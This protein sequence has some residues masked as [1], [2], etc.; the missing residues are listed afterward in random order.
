M[1]APRVGSSWKSRIHW[2]GLNKIQVR[3]SGLLGS[4]SSSQAIHKGHTVRV[5][6]T[7]TRDAK[8]VLSPGSPGGIQAPTHAQGHV[9]VLFELGNQGPLPS[10]EGDRGDSSCW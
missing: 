6:I 4:K 1:A 2:K 8:A 5:I 10:F 3:W 7:K 9:G